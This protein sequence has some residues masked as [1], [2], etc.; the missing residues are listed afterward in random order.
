M[1]KNVS[2]FINE[3]NEKAATSSPPKTSFPLAQR[4]PARKPATVNRQH[5]ENK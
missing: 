2:D 3:H 1:K 5:D 4:K